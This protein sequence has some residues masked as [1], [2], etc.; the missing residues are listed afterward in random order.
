M[1]KYIIVLGLVI[2]LG[3][4][5]IFL[6][7]D[8]GTGH[9]YRSNEVLWSS[10][11]QNNQKKR[12]SINKIEVVNESCDKIVFRVSYQNTGQ[13]DG[14][15]RFNTSAK[16]YV[17]GSRGDHSKTLKKGVASDIYEQWITDEVTKANTNELWVSLEEIVDEKFHDIVDRVKIPFSKTWDHECK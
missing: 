13:T 6:K 15:I 9:V 11:E 8:L 12:A 16:P 7:V 2:V 17:K 4:G 3:A 1:K 14:Y 10:A 5:F